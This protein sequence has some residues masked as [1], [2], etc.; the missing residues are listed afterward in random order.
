MEANEKTRGCSCQNGIGKEDKT[1]TAIKKRIARR[2]AI[3]CASL[4]D[5]LTCNNLSD[6]KTAD[7]LSTIRDFAAECT[8]ANNWSAEEFYLYGKAL[9]MF[10]VAYEYALPRDNSPQ[11]PTTETAK[12]GAEKDKCKQ[13]CD[14][15]EDAGFFCYFDC[16]LEYAACLAGNVLH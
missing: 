7:F 3:L 15:D 11:P 1:E 10:E 12:C 8:L 14:G 13:G 6:R 2:A 5:K 16:R 4:P 9:E